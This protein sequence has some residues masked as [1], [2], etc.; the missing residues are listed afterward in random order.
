MQDTK[1]YVEEKEWREGSRD[2]L[3]HSVAMRGAADRDAMTW[4]WQ[5]SGSHVGADQVAPRNELPSATVASTIS[6]V[7]TL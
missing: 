2:R 1:A 6:P 7:R 5:S 4:V 3:A